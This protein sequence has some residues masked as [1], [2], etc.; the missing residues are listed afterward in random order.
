[1]DI[2]LPEGKVLVR[3]RVKELIPTAKFANVDIDLELIGYAE[4]LLDVKVLKAAG[5]ALNDA[6]DTADNVLN[7][8]R[9]PIIEELEGGQ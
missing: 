4:D 3:A 9:I 6:Y 7:E 2:N 5:K 8:K 1:M